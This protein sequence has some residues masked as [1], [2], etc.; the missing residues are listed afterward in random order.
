MSEPDRLVALLVRPLRRAAAAQRAAVARLRRLGDEDAIAALLARWDRLPPCAGFD[1]WTATAWPPAAEAA[2]T[3]TAAT[4]RRRAVAALG[5]PTRNPASA[6]PSGLVPSSAAPGGAAAGRGQP[7]REYAPD[8]Q[9]A[10]RMPPHTVSPG[11][12]AVLPATPDSG[13]PSGHGSGSTAGS[14]TDRSP[15]SQAAGRAPE[16][17]SAAALSAAATPS[18]AVLRLPPEQM[19]ARDRLSPAAPAAADPRA[20]T[21]GMALLERQ[22]QALWPPAGAAPPR[23]P[24]FGSPA[25]PAA[26]PAAAP[27]LEPAPRAA[28]RLL[29]DA[30]PENAAGAAP[31]APA[32]AAAPPETARTARTPTNA[33]G[34]GDD[35]ALARELNRLLL[36][37][38]WLR[39]VD[40]S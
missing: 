37:Q 7:G 2:G 25:P 10:H 40:L 17:R 34:D 36:D 6:A 12:P 24:A 14:D 21:H 38:A 3:V 22:L 9:P 32:R 27:I 20:M 33:A 16:S 19:A 26:A 1:P 28:S 11:T 39:G 13:R 5:T 15:R 4:A 35:D 31:S 29:A 30:A 18:Q 23:R 8:A